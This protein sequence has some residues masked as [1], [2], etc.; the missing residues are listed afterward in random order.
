MLN[1]MWATIHD[2]RIE[3][4]EQVDL[5]EGARVL[6]TLLPDD[7]ANYDDANCGEASFWSG[8]SENSL[9][10]VWDNTEDDVYAQLLDQ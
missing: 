5:P 6:V 1:S 9:A 4:A 8:A 7:D 10:G 3:L 2:G